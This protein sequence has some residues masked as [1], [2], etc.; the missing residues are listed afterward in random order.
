MFIKVVIL[1]M[2]YKF[3]KKPKESV[4]I[5]EF[6]RTIKSLITGNHPHNSMGPH[7]LKLHRSVSHTFPMKEGFPSAFWEGISPQQVITTGWAAVS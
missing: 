1:G 5:N 2:L 7:S 4:L 3:R 6:Q